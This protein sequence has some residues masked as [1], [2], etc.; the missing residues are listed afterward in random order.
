VWVNCN[1]LLRVV[2][3]YWKLVA[4]L[5]VEGALLRAGVSQILSENITE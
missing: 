1:V 2:S 4:T 3:P 5:E